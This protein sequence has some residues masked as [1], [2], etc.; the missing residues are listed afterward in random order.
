MLHRVVNRFRSACARIVQALALLTVV[1]HF[2]RAVPAGAQ[3]PV[4]DLRAGLVDT[5]RLSLD[6]ARARALAA[7]P[8]LLAARLDTAIARGWLRQAGVLRFN[9]S[10]DALTGGEGLELGLSQ[11][12]EVFGQRGLRIAAERAGLA[13]ASAAVANETRITLGQVDRSFFGLV[14][15]TQRRNLARE[16]LALNERLAEIA[17]RQL[18][19]G[20]ISRLGFNLSVVELGRARALE[21]ARR[22]EQQDAEVLL[23]RL[24]GLSPTTTPIPVLDETTGRPAIDSAMGS[25]RGAADLSPEPVPGL[26]V[27]SLTALALVPHHSAGSSFRMTTTLCRPSDSSVA[28]RLGEELEASLGLVDTPALDAEEDLAVEGLEDVKYA[29]PVDH[30][31]SAGAPHRRPGHLPALLLAVL[32]ADVLRMDVADVVSNLLERFV[33]ILNASEI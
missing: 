25:G 7:N 19:E 5:V 30:A 31:L 17:A 2:V 6:N 26:D 27:D 32:E 22:R 1:G 28:H 33:W 18:A 9:P 29:L 11:E 15:A 14:A 24:I 12:I 13:R 21:L 20:E 3:T 4:P 16:V 8:D 23:S 10:A